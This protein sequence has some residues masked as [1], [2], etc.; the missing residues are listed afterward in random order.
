MKRNPGLGSFSCISEHRIG[1]LL[2]VLLFMIAAVPVAMADPRGNVTRGSATGT[3]YPYTGFQ[4]TDK[5]PCFG[6][7]LHCTLEGTVAR[8]RL[9]LLEIDWG[10]G[11]RNETFQDP[12]DLERA[13]HIYKK[14]RNYTATITGYRWNFQGAREVY[15]GQYYF[16]LSLVKG[17]I[18]VHAIDNDSPYSSTLSPYV[19]GHW[20]H[21]AMYVG[22]DQ[23]IESGWNSVRL[24]PVSEFVYPADE[25]VAIYRVPGLT[26]TQREN[27]VNYAK[28]KLGDGYDVQSLLLQFEG[29]Q[30]DNDDFSCWKYIGPVSYPRCKWACSHYYCSELVW[31]A[32]RKNGIDFDPE[33]GCVY[34]M[35]L[36]L[37]RHVQVQLVGTHIEKIPKR[38]MAYS[39][40]DRYYMLLLNSDAGAVVKD[41]P[42]SGSCESCEEAKGTVAA[43]TNAA[44][45]NARDLFDTRITDPDG[46]SMT[47]TVTTIPSSTVGDLDTDGDNILEMMD[48]IENAGEGEYQ[49]TVSPE[50]RDPE[51]YVYSLRIG[52]WDSDQISWIEPVNF[53][54]LRS[55]P[56]GGKIRMRIEENGY[57]RMIGIPVRGT[58]PLNVSFMDISPL[59][60]SSEEWDYDNTVIDNYW[61]FGDETS[62]ANAVTVTHQ[63]TGPGSYTVRLTTRNATMQGTA[64]MTVIVNA[65]EQPLCAGFGATPLSG[66]SPLTVQFTDASTGNPVRYFYEFGDGVSGTGKNP[67]HTYRKPGTYTVTLTVFAKDDDGKS[68]SNT[69]V[70]KDL[71]TV[72]SN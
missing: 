65:P 46:R 4:C 16:N 8:G 22:D 6:G 34:P 50:C 59:M 36:V 25:C 57:C 24:S 38:T 58:A 5:A 64:T 72:V 32:Y 54:G 43:N 62:A 37:S 55:L 49:I 10:D 45:P 23:V 63:Y 41:I 19:P 31:A 29:K 17:D 61:D 1:I 60:R 44:T 35:D 56:D 3:V 27:I 18:I 51:N 14:P 9:D 39:T 53:T 40:T 7:R 28:E 30:Q 70:R 20:T 12:K 2:I 42:A 13:T 15:T 68:Y 52:A 47:E 21:A 26:D 33:F 11:S 71:V 66:T 67:S 48:S 69:T